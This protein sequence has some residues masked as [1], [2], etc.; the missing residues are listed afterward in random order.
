MLYEPF[1]LNRVP[2]ARARHVSYVCYTSRSPKSGDRRF[3]HAET[4]DAHPRITDE[5]SDLGRWS[6]A[7][8]TVYTFS[9][10]GT[11]AGSRALD[12]RR[13]LTLHLL[14]VLEHG[15]PWHSQPRTRTSLTKAHA[16][17]TLHL[18]VFSGTFL[19]GRREH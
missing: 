17:L 5:L 11:Y 4:A 18:C 3:A 8:C 2:L 15:N 13:L 16:G 1:T 12:T 19:A 9:L 6:A 7:T 14:N 10:G